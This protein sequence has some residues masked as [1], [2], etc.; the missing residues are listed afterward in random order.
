MTGTPIRIEAEDMLLSGYRTEDFS[1]LTFASGKAYTSLFGQGETEIGIA[2][3]QFTGPAGEY[4]IV[5][6][7]FDESDG[8]S[9]FNITKNGEEISDWLADSTG[10][11]IAPSAQSLV[12]RTIPGISLANGDTIQLTGIEDD[13]E[14]ARIDYIE[15]IPIEST[16]EE[17]TG[18]VDNTTGEP[19]TT[20]E[21]DATGSDTTASDTAGAGTIRVEA[22]SMTLRGYRTESNSDFT[23][24]SG[25]SYASLFEKGKAEKGIATT[26]FTGETGTYDVVIA[27]FDEDDG[28]SKFKFKQNGKQTDI[29]D[30]TNTTGGSGPSAQ[31][32]VRRTLSG[33]TIKNGDRIQL[34]GSEGDGEAA[35]ID[36]IEFVPSNGAE[37]DNT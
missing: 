16:D 21:T 37:T 33:L 6:A 8:V 36:Y 13:A 35:R 5:V 24:A 34:V 22:E 29:W 11:G 10:G 20:D 30:A 28:V 25:N 1:S 4:D 31:S 19:D 3:T 32:L 23:F 9:Q 18:E 17:T 15:L 14:A 27:Y 26:F 2:T 12:R 7:Y